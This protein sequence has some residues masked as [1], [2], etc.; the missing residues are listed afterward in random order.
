MTE[1]EYVH[2]VRERVVRDK[3]QRLFN[4]ERERIQTLL[5]GADIQHVGSTAIADSVTKGDL[6]LQVRVSAE[7]FLVAVDRLSATYSKN[8]GSDWTSDFAAFKDDA[9][10]PPLG[11]QLCIMGSESDFFWKIRDVLLANEGLRHEYDALKNSF[12]GRAMAE[13]REAKRHFMEKVMKTE[14][15]LRL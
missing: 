7:L 10:D 5:P 9:T 4:I 2:F 11:V 3:V 15:F 1:T 6:D 13:Y 14:A 8:E 12:Q